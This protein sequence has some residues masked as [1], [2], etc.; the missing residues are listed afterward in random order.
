MNL[1]DKVRAIL[2][3]SIEKRDHSNME[4]IE[5]SLYKEIYNKKQHSDYVK[6]HYDNES[7]IS[8]KDIQSINEDTSRI[9]DLEN[10]I[11]MSEFVLFDDITSISIEYMA[12]ALILNRNIAKNAENINKIQ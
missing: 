6:S 8:D 4:D 5:D 11:H 12:G 1:E 7:N 10:A 3:L 2:I 9:K